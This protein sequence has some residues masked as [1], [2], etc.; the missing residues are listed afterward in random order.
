MN[1]IKHIAASTLGFRA[2]L[3]LGP[4]GF[5]AFGYYLGDLNAP[6][7]QSMIYDDSTHPSMA[8]PAA[9]HNP[10]P[11]VYVPMPSQ[12][13]FDLSDIDP[14]LYTNII[15]NGIPKDVLRLTGE[16]S[17][18]DMIPEDVSSAYLKA[19]KR[20]MTNLSNIIT[21]QHLKDIDKT[22]GGRE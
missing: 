21:E 22:L 5:F 15:D 11:P 8:M 10:D 19:W 6:L 16:L 12:S 1:N 9:T 3:I 14:A 4:L 13:P 7:T 20:D 18:R 17:D 2:W